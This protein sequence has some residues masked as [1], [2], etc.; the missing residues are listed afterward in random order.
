MQKILNPKIWNS[1]ETLKENVYDDLVKIANHFIAFTKIPVDKVKDIIFV[2]SMANY[3]WHT[4]SDIDLHIIFDS[5]KSNPD[6]LEFISEYLLDKKS[7]W[8]YK[9]TISI[10]KFPVELYPEFDNN[11]SIHAS[12][13]SIKNKQWIKE[14][15]YQNIEDQLTLNQLEVDKKYDDYVNKIDYLYKL[16]KKS[17][18]NLEELLNKIIELKKD[19]WGLRK[20]SLKTDSIYSVGNLIFKELRNT[21]YLDKLLNLETEIYDKNLTIENID[22][23]KE[24]YIGSVENINNKKTSIFKNPTN[25]SGFPNDIRGAIDENGNLYLTNNDLIMHRDIYKFLQNYLNLDPYQRDWYIK[26]P[27]T[28][29][30]LF[31]TRDEDSNRFEVADSYGAINMTTK[32]QVDKQLF[33]NQAKKKNI[34]FNFI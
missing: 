18:T 31:I 7:L 19:I 33:Y 10:Y 23:L 5:T 25:I 12:I 29:K 13:Y 15:V 21:D 11:T 2:G 3:N 32:F 34:L 14:P 27:S 20:E 1:N 30:L 6:Q 17:N 9:H 16:S 22:I 24:D 28:I 26:P 4:K 8:N